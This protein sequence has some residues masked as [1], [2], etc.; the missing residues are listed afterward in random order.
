MK[1]YKI[2]G[3]T[4]SYIANRD[5][6]FNGKTEIVIAEGLKLKE[7]YEKLLDMFN[8]DYEVYAENWRVA[9]MLTRN[10]CFSASPTYKDGTRSY[11]YD[12][13]RYSIEIE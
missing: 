6:K 12:G 10:Q 5:I 3:R 1:I 9:V 7:A 13:R 11:E 8:E 4:N 2:V